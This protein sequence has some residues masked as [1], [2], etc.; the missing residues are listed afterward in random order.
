MSW[1][2]QMDPALQDYITERQSRA[3]RV[4][5]EDHDLLV[6][7]V[8]Q[9]DS[10]RS[11]GYGARQIPELL[12]NAVDALA[13]NGAPGRIEFRLADGA[14]YCANEGLPFD[15]AGVRAVTYAFLSGKRQDE[16]G[17][18]GLGFKSI[19]G[20]TANP[21]VFSHSVSFEF[22][23]DGTQ[24]LF[25]GIPN[26]SGRL[27][28][29]RIPSLADPARAM[30]EDRHLA[31]LMSWA[32]TVIK[33]PL[34]REGAR[35]HHEL[36]E[37]FEA[38]SL[39]FLDAI[40]ELRITTLDAHQA[41]RVRAFRREIDALAG[42]VTLTAPVGDPVVWL[43]E[44]RQYEPSEEVA[45]TLPET[46]RRKRMTV[47][48]AVNPEKRSEVGQL[49]SWF[50]LQ[51]KT[52]AGG[53]F[54]APW[55]INDDRTTLVAHS[56]LNGALLEV[57]AELFLDVAVRASSRTDPAAHLDLFPAR[58]RE[59]RSR[60]D[61]FLSEAI[62]RH[63]TRRKMIPDRRGELRSPSYFDG[64]PDLEA[65]PLSREAVAEWNRL[66]DRDTVPHE[67]CFGSD[68]RRLRLRSLLRGDSGSSRERS[69][70]AWVEEPVAA[71][72]HEGVAGALR[73]AEILTR[74]R[75]IR[76]EDVLR[77]RIVP[78]EDGGVRLSI[79]AC[80]SCCRATTSRSRL[81]SSS[82]RVMSSRMRIRNRS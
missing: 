28:L 47:S 74:S 67:A 11:G 13:R 22:N 40:D 10:F 25:A 31:E 5:E 26:D 1:P 43:Y 64:I 17:R 61:A 65:A 77:A 8:R 48:Y 39:L 49:W 53:R 50:P 29:L 24:E 37:G 7:H 52:T 69:L 23:A 33:L 44:Q 2:E 12:Q 34:Q 19:L 21:Q 76:R 57:A 81:A 82:S 14:L 38:E 66:V 36:T 68:A 79:D 73:V 9:E 16:I 18:F 62:P 35:I 78:L 41:P 30:A 70:A 15:Q 42:T 55:Q 56:A 45:S 58:G 71:G 4:Y 80:R 20:I 59:A 72:T 63:A 27:P 32:T 54:N 60:A 6:E 51:D 46:M 75:G 3:L